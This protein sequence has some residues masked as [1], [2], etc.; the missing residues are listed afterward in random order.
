VPT[1]EATIVPTA[2]P[3]N[4][5]TGDV[6]L[7]VTTSDGG[8]IPDTSR[9]CIADQ[10]TTAGASTASVSAAAISGSSFTF[11]SLPSG[12]QAVTITNDVPYADLTTTATVVAG[13]TITVNVTLVPSAAPTA[14]DSGNATPVT[15]VSPTAVVSVPTAPTAPTGSSPSGTTVKAL[16]N[17]G[18]GSNASSSAGLFVLL[19]AMMVTMVIA[20]I[21]YRRRSR[22]V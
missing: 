1:A 8:T 15:T 19:G 18:T 13:G 21:A 16:P 3:T 17:T 12:P 7:I 4:E 2:A 10:C 14:P 22:H 9:I 5:T 20:A 11:T 6:T